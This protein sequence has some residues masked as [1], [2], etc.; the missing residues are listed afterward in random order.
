MRCGWLLR[1][2]RPALNI[3][4][5]FL[6]FSSSDEEE[7]FFP[8]FTI[9]RLSSPFLYLFGLLF[10]IFKMG[11]MTSKEKKKHKKRLQIYG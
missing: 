10:L 9:K 2:K 6:L 7:V 5:S 3:F 8:R 4:T 1:R 11:M